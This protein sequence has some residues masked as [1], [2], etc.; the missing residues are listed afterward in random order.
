MKKDLI[1]LDKKIGMLV[2]NN[3]E[4]V[5]LTDIAGYKNSERTEIVIQNWVRNRNTVEFLGLWEMLNNQN[6]KHLEF[7][8]IRKRCGLNSFVL[9]PKQWIEK[10]NAIGIISKPGRYGG[11]Y[12]HKNIAFEFASWIS[13]KFKL[14]LITEFERLKK[15]EIDKKNLDWDIKRNLAKINYNLHAFAIKENLIPKKISK[16]HEK[17]IYANEAEILNVALFGITSKQ[18]KQKSPDKIGGLRDYANASQLVCLSNLES[19]NSLLI[20]EGINQKERLIKLNDVAIYQMKILVNDLNVK[21][22]EKILG[23]KDD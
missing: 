11:T 12:A 19:L 10:T 22:F 2:K 9:T 3:E 6:F 8:V 5:S 18:W 15:E 13:P 23:E 14:Y 20:N 7:D 1:V 21:Y 17:I 4:Y 16:E